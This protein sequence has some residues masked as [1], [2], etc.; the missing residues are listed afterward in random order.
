MVGAIMAPYMKHL[1]FLA[2]QMTVEEFSLGGT[3]VTALRKIEA[4]GLGETPVQTGRFA[5]KP[6]VADRI[7]K[8]STNSH[9]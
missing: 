9:S 6:S 4:L 5:H 1:R 8:L 3:L 2:D 7:Q